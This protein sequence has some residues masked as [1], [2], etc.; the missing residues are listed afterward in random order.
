MVLLI[1]SSVILSLKLKYFSTMLYS[2]I[3]WKIIL[4]VLVCSS[5]L[6]IK[7]SVTIVLLDK[8][9]E[10]YNSF[11]RR[12]EKKDTLVWPILFPLYYLVTEYIPLFCF[13]LSIYKSYKLSRK[14]TV[15]LFSSQIP[16]SNRN[17][18]RAHS[19]N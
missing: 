1:G 6:L 17:S 13:L 12:Q 5:A 11:L 9:S 4:V 18:D 3:K 15:E 19:V 2:A 16:S 8:G 10:A 7:I 14:R